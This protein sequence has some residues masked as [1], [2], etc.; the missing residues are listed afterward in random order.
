L[1]VDR[2][3]AVD[4]WPPVKSVTNL[5]QTRSAVFAI[6]NDFK[7]HVPEELYLFPAEAGQGGR[8]DASASVS[9]PRSEG[10]SGVRYFGYSSPTVARVTS[11]DDKAH[12][13]EP[14]QLA[15]KRGL[16]Q[17]ESLALL[18]LRQVGT[19]MESAHHD[20][21]T[22]MQSVFLCLFVCRTVHSLSGS[23]QKPGDF[24]VD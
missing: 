13:L 12:S 11:A 20:V 9:Y 1:G 18:T 16:I 8:F 10:R 5:L 19:H 21:V 6:T 2:K 24:R 4:W 14:V 15:H 17:T 3:T 7:E 22:K 23:V